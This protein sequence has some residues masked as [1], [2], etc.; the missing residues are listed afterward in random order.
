MGEVPSAVTLN[1]TFV[2]VK[3][4]SDTSGFGATCAANPRDDIT[5]N[6]RID[7]VFFI[8]VFNVS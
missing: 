8:F 5:N 6:D 1:V 4:V 7:N 2:L 3:T